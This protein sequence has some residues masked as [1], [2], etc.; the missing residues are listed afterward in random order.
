M[1]WSE[2]FRTKSGGTTSKREPIL[3]ILDTFRLKI[4]RSI[5][6]T[7]FRIFLGFGERKATV[8]FTI[9]SSGD[10]SAVKPGNCRTGFAGKNFTTAQLSG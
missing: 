1:K 9:A 4:N 3:L 7:D 2:R 8:Y 10:F 5:R 6:E